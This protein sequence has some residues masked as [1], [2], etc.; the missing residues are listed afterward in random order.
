M[1]LSW[2][3]AL[4]VVAACLVGVL[5]PGH[6]LAQG[7]PRSGFWI[8]AGAGTGTLRSACSACPS[9]T[10]AYGT[11]NHLRLGLT[12]APRVLLGLEFFALR[13]TELELAAG[14]MPVDAENGSIAPI[15][16]WYVGRSGFFLKGGIGL[17]RGTYT[18]ESTVGPVT[19][20]RTGSSISFSIGYDI[21]ITSWLALTA[22]LGTY[23]SA[24]GDVPLNGVTVDDLIATVYEAAVGLTLR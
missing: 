16:I 4:P 2:R 6:V 17:A 3:V 21:G 8:E 1:R 13:S 7:G 24:I 18:V 14:A 11:A 15:V 9:V 20:E 22:N 10:V 12:L 19:T 23:T 5:L